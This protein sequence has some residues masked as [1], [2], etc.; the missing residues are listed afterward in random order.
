MYLVGLWAIILGVM[1]LCHLAALAAAANPAFDRVLGTLPVIGKLRRAFALSRFCLAYDMQ[2]EAGIN[3][4][5]AIETAGQASGSGSYVAAAR[6]AVPAL[7]NGESLSVALQKT[8]SFPPPL[9]RAF[10]VGED[11][12]QLE[13]E[14]KRAATEYR[15]SA[16]RRLDFIVEWSPRIALIFVAVFIGWRLVSYYTGMFHQIGLETR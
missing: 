3:V 8:G 15:D 12:G 5:S 2:L 13:V 10:S 4:M 11:T 14:L 16:I 7:R 6:A 9:L 1:F